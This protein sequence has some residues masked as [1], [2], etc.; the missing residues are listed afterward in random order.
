MIPDQNN[1]EKNFMKTKKINALVFGSQLKKLSEKIIEIMEDQNNYNNFGIRKLNENNFK[2]KTSYSGAEI[3][4]EYIY[5]LYWEIKNIFEINE[6]D[7]FAKRCKLAKEY[8][9]KTLEDLINLRDLYFEYC[10]EDWIAMKKEEAEEE[11]REL[12]DKEIDLD[13]FYENISDLD[14]N[15]NYENYNNISEALYILTESD[16]EIS[17]PDNRIYIY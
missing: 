4:Y 13:N 15:Y 6:S 5:D 14:Y 12:S 17:L 2:F 16:D 1:Q 8:L 7:K 11:D 9:D 10:Y 3:C